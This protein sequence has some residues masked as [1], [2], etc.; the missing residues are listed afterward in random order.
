[1]KSIYSVK[2][3]IFAFGRIKKGKGKPDGHETCPININ[4]DS[5]QKQ[6]WSVTLD[7]G[8]SRNWDFAPDKAAN[9]RFQDAGGGLV[10]L[11]QLIQQYAGEGGLGKDKRNRQKSVQNRLMER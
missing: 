1:M 8:L 11:C 9:L 5:N 3:F 10:G 7:D 4:K 2:I 6:T